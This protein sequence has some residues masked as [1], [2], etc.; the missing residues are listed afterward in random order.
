MTSR[1]ILR[2]SSSVSILTLALLTAS[3]ARSQDATN[4]NEDATVLKPIIITGEKVARD[5]KSTASSVAIKSA[6]EIEKEKTGNATVSEVIADTAN[7][8]FPDNVSAPIIRGQDTQGPNTGA[9]AFFAGTVPRA[10]INVDGHYLG[11][12]EFI[13]GATS[14][15]DVESIEVF[16]GPQTTSQGANAIAGAIVVNTKDPTFTPEG[17]YQAELGSYHTKRASLALSGPIVGE[18]LAARIA[19][20]YSGRDTFIDYINSGFASKGTDQ[21]FME[22]NARLK[23]LWE[24]SE[25]PG[26]STKLTLSHS[27]ANRPSQ[28]AASVPFDAL[29]HTTTTMPS[30][31]Q[32][33]DTAILDI[34]YDF[35]NGVK[36][37]NQTQFTDS[38]AKRRVGVVNNGDADVDQTNVSEEVRVTFG[39]QDDTLSGVVGIF[40]NHTQ[41]DEAL[42]LAYNGKTTSTFDDQK[43]NLGLFTEMTYRLSDQWSLTGGLRYQRDQIQRS[44]TSVYAANPVDFD[45]TFSAVLPKASIAY[46]V[47]DDWTVGALVSRGYNPG[48]V[49]LNISAQKW[50]EFKEEKLWNYELFTRANLLDDRLTLTGN[51]FYMDMKNAQYNIP[52]QVTSTLTQSYTINAE[53]AHAYGLEIGG[54]YRVLDNL[55]FKANAGLLKTEIERMSSNT[56]YEGNEF[57]KSPGYMVSFG[58]SWDVT[59]KFNVSGQVRHLDGYYSDIGNTKAYVIE[60]YTIA[61]VRASYQFREG[62]K[63][64]GYVKNVFDERAPTYMQQNRGIGGLEASMTAPRMFGIGVKGSF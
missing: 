4:Q 13:Y 14:A 2:F 9:T 41:A 42:Y 27:N 49:S 12:N 10:T 23:F 11:Y 38:N 47:T 29:N 20:D 6:R 1:P 60:P 24:P 55:T 46:A 50:M 34:S 19:I 33:T 39:E 59:E 28:E 35:E 54:D 37:F 48:G 8:V 63:V 30:W 16:R 31:R 22:F 56:T 64:Y 58:A 7:V 40:Y 21:D 51:L 15:W 57:A 17:A 3:P 32:R 36:V 18:D 44:G 25:I 53:E 52:V 43:D 5:L 61:D 62:L 45:T 26:L